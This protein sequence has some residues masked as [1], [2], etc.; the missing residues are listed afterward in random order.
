MSKEEI[1]AILE[2][3]YKLWSRYSYDC[4]HYEILFHENKLKELNQLASNTN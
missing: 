4:F 1:E 2:E 3:C